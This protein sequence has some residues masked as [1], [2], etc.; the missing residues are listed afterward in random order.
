MATDRQIFVNLPVHDLDRTIRF[1]TALGF[2]FNQEFTDNNAACMVIA[3]NIFAMLLIE[4]F[5]A[6]FIPGR[7]IADTSSSTEAL[8]AVSA[9]SRDAVDT[10]IRNAESAGGN[11]YR[12]PQDHGWMYG[13]AF[14]DPDGHIW[15]VIYMDEVQLAA[16]QQDDTS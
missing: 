13:R 15:E 1:F 8:I 14:Q 3:P 7:Q 11:E 4:D 6:G 9:D 10:M 12:E 2:E 5:F 16:M